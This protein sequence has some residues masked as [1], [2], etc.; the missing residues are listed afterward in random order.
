[1][2]SDKNKLE[3]VQSDNKKLKDTIKCLKDDK[4]KTVSH[5]EK[6]MQRLKTRVQSLLKCEECEES[7]KLKNELKNHTQ[8]KHLVQEYKCAVCDQLFVDITDM[9]MHFKESHCKI[10]FKC[11]ECENNFESSE[12]LKLHISSE[13]KRNEYTEKMRKKEKAIEAQV[14]K[15]KVTLYDSLY[16]LKQKDS[17]KQ[18][19]FCRG[20]YCRIVHSR[21]RWI[22]S[23]S[24]ILLNKLQ[25]MISQEPNKSKLKYN[26]EK[27]DFKC[28]YEDSLKKHIDWCLIRMIAL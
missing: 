21:F 13:H 15:Q 19:C 24:D 4:V 8:S 28:N 2:K 14:L 7:F 10:L 9:K 1:M 16:K 22:A 12:N 25:S 23:K 18:K 17:L 3:D 20:G 6:E 27:C 11:N 5:L 26:C